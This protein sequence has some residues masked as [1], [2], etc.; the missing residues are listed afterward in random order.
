MAEGTRF[1]RSAVARWSAAACGAA[2]LVGLLWPVRGEAW[3][4]LGGTLGLDQRD[5]RVHRNFTGPEADN[6]T[7]THPDYPGADGVVLAIWKA[8]AEWGSEPHGTGQGDPSQPFGLGSGGANFD[9][10]YQGLAPDPG[11]TNDNVVSELVG[12][13]GGTL[14]FTEL[15]IDNGWRIRFYS[16]AAQW[17]DDPTGPS[18]GGKDLQGVATH[19][20][21]HALGL[22]HTLV[23]GATMRTNATGTLTY[24]RSLH[25]DDIA[26]VQG[27]YGVRSATK[28]H[29]ERYE[30][31]PGGAV[32]LHG[33]RFAPTGNRVWFTPASGG[34]GTPLEAGPV[35]ST[36]GG[37]RIDLTLPA[38]VG[39][40]DVVVRIPGSDGAALSNAFPFDPANDPCRTPESYGVAKTTSTG[41][42]VLLS[43][44]GFPSAS[45]GDFAITA[46][47]GPPNAVG[48]LFYGAGEA[49][50]P[51]MGGTLNVAPPYVRARPMRFNFLGSAGASVPVDASL[52]GR[53]RWYQL[54]FPDANDP[55]GV[56]LS[57]GLRVTFCR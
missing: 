27:L 50:S 17:D 36:A 32:A 37:T 2:A 7:A 30:L 13:G 35:D 12:G 5:F 56:G 52:E 55:F 1:D 24:M 8:A 54:W 47:G 29:V 28:P 33:E 44:S 22:A 48:V 46:T 25:P 14:A 26:G 18:P 57:D 23:S 40:G 6:S 51:F 31:G 53:T 38:G 11:D 3:V 20:F 10:V 43:W 4:P 19:E 16:G 42:Q 15:P 45:T 21:G 41:G 49:A 39:A 34:D 9:F